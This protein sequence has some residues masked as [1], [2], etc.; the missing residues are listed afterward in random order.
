MKRNFFLLLA[1]CLLS[2]AAKAQTVHMN[3]FMVNPPV[4]PL[5]GVLNVDYDL[6][7]N[8][9]APILGNID[10][11]LSVDG[12]DQGIKNTYMLTA[13]LFPGQFVHIAFTLLASPTNGFHIQ[14]N[15]IVII[16]PTGGGFTRCDNQGNT[17]I[18]ITP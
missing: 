10:S 5:N 6:I 12:M 2:F 4:V 15:S 13:P 3:N 8:G 18:N 1:V 9:P 14:S 16:W 7:N 17:M 11:H